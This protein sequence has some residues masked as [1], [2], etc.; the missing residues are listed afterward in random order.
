MDV[1]I[2]HGLSA[3]PQSH[4]FPWLTEQ[5]APEG[6]TVTVPAMPDTERPRLDAWLATLA[7][8]PIGADT[9]L[10]G[11]SLGAITVVRHLLREGGAPVRG[12]LLLAGF[13]APVPG[14]PEIDHF[15]DDLPDL[16]GFAAVAPRRHVIASD[17]DA[18]APPVLTHEL[19]GRIDAPLEEIAGGGHFLGREGWTEMPRVLE[20]LRSWR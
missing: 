18:V 17:D 14:L 11:H 9:V 6:V 13:V 20:L 16:D 5:L 19:A 12:A 3:T 4:W 10:V 1:V 2:V 7:E 15:T 8:L